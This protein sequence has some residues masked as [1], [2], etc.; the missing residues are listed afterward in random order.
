MKKLGIALIVAALVFGLIQCD[1]FTKKVEYS[2]SSDGSGSV[3]IRY[4]DSKGQLVDAS[5]VPP[6]STSFDLASTDRPF[7]A[8]IEV[9]NFDASTVYISILQDNAIVSTGQIIGVGSVEV[10]YI[11]E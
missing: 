9:T 4:Q 2:V 6:W 5:A 10:Y 3:S 8:F 11:V 7:L 1:L